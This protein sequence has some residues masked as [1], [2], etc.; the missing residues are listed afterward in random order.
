[1]MQKYFTANGQ[2]YNEGTIVR[3]KTDEGSKEMTFYNISNGIYCLKCGNKFYYY[4][5]TDFCNC[6]INIT[7]RT[8]GQYLKNQQLYKNKPTNI[9][10]LD[11]D[12]ML[13]AWMWYVLIMTI[14]IIFNGR[15]VIW[16]V[17]SIIFFNYRNKKLREAGV[18][19]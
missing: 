16:S 5:E 11:I 8:D 1:M 14:A 4:K 17:A 7:N 9:R 12:G 10:E 3:I 19:K 15:I 18:Q 13:Y 2:K 6:L